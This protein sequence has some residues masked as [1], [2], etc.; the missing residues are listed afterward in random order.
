MNPPGWLASSASPLL[1]LGFGPLAGAGHV[2]RLLANALGVACGVGALLGVAYTLFAA[3][4]IG[5]FF[6]RPTAEPGSSRTSRSSSPCAATSGRSFATWPASASR[7]TRARFNISSVCRMPGIPLSGP[8][9]SCGVCYP[10]AQVTVVADSRLYGPNRKVSNLINMMPQARHGVLVFADS[11]VGV[12]PDYLRNVIGELQRPGVELVTCVYRGEPDPGFWPRLSA[13]ATDYQFLPSVVTGL[14]LGLARP[15]FGQTIAMRRETLERIGGLARLRTIWPRT[16]RS[17]RRCAPGAGPVAIPAFAISHA[18]A[19][20]SF[21]RLVGARIA[22][23]P[24]HPGGRPCGAPRLAR[25]IHPF[26]LGVLAVVFSGGAA[27]SWPVAAAALVARLALKLRTDRALRR[28][29]RDLWLLPPWDLVSFALF[30]GELLLEKGGLARNRLQGGPQRDAVPGARGLR[31]HVGSL[32]GVG[33]R[34]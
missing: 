13:M 30:L 11:D 20:T 29:V 9:T 6:A 4:A 2:A 33:G 28:P 23:E 17:G 15:C 16:M 12:A 10:E 32:Q 31:E 22:L 21:A 25:S 18:C 3:V 5:R 24:H 19:E 8:S 14:A 7:T 1:L 34:M 27:W 26:A